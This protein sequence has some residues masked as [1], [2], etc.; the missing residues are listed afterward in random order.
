MSK[1]EV[2]Y[3]KLTG[4]FILSISVGGLIG[5]FLFDAMHYL[6]GFYYGFYVSIT[7]C[8]TAYITYSLICFIKENYGNND[9]VSD[10]T[11]KGCIQ[12]I[13]YVISIVAVIRSIVMM[14]SK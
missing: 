6:G 8:Y 9:E 13:V 7:T 10:L 3:A 1:E 14:V 12:L 11:L 5:R 4:K 2:S